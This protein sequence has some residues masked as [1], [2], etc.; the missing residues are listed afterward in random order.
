MKVG[1]KDFTSVLYSKLE[2]IL[3]SVTDCVCSKVGDGTKMEVHRG[4]NYLWGLEEYLSAG[5]GVSKERV[6]LSR[7]KGCRKWKSE[8]E[9]RE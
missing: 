2:K 5:S 6:H 9:D 8:I 4:Y 1:G 3:F 7:P